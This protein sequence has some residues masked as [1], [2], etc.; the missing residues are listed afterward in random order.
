MSSALGLDF[1][2]TN[3]VLAMPGG[4]DHAQAISLTVDDAPVDTLRSALCFWRTQDA[5]NSVG[6]EA[7][8]YA[9]RQFIEDPEDSR[10]IQSFKTFAA[11]PSFQGTYIYGK[12]YT[13]DALLETFLSRVFDYAKASLP[14]LPERV[15]IGRPVAY[16]GAGPDASLAM[17]RYENAL[18]RLGFKEVVFV[19]EPVAAAF[20]FARA[21]TKPATILVADFGGGTTDFSI[22][23]FDFAGGVMKARALGHGGIGIAGDHFDYRIINNVILPRIGKGTKYRDMF[24]ESELPDSLFAAFSRWNSLSILKTSNEFRELK[25]LLRRCL[26]PKKIER[27][28]SLVED[29]QGYPLYKAISTLKAQLSFDDSAT[30][31]FPPLGENF[32]HT[33]KRSDFE[34]WIQDDLDRI[35]TKLVETMNA[36]HVREYD[37]DQVFLTGGTSFVPAVRAIFERRFGAKKIESGHE[38]ISIANGLALIGARPDYNSWAVNGDEIAA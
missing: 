34:T 37:I 25:K 38:L 22:M 11:S 19:Y 12:R 6:V 10:F 9:I 20:F 16:A 5:L 4:S 1:G 8:P 15:V 21:L 2:T 23:K 32:S 13:F 36:S 29:D 26:E 30:L 7:G 28:I 17:Q 33:I 27:F 35:E 18:H 3:T 24:K 31:R 14:V